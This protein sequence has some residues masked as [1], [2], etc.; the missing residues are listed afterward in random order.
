MADMMKVALSTQAAAAY[1]GEGAQLSFNGEEALIHLGAAGQQKD[2]LR[3][4]QRAA[5]RLEA[6]GIKRVMLAGEG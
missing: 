1:W 3:T 5:R 2:V 4:V 6:S